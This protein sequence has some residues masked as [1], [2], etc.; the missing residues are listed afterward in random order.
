MCSFNEKLILVGENVNNQ[1]NIAS[2]ISCIF[3]FELKVFQQ[4][5]FLLTEFV[6]TEI[7]DQNYWQLGILSRH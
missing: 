3:S 1:E 5:V 4:G 7:F 2:D 6:S